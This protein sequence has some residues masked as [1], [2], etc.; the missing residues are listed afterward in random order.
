MKEQT[1]NIWDCFDTNQ[2]SVIVITTNGSL[3]RKGD[4]VMGRGIAKEAADRFPGLRRELG[5]E[6][7]I[8]GNKLNYFPKYRLI[9]FPVKKSWEQRADP[10]L[11]KKSLKEL[12]KLVKKG[13]IA[14]WYTIYM[15]R[16]GC[17]NGFLKWADVKGILKP[18]LSDR[19]VIVEKN[20]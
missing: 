14:D 7:E 5:A 4:A 11:I 8:Y 10:K 1:G 17:G 9:T 13:C 18:K 16:P 3:N 12:L 2:S 20:P 6:L 19:F 15:V